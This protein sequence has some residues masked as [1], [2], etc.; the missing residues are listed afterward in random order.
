MTPGSTKL[1]L[2]LPTLSTTL[3]RST[4]GT[5]SKTSKASSLSDRRST[6]ED[7]GERAGEVRSRS[8]CLRGA[9]E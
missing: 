2:D 9:G 6:N 7:D 4:A 5:M 3:F 1:Y 8:Q